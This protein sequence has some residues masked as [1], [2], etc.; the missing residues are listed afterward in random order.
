MCS[1]EII[2]TC[3][4]LSDSR[5]APSLCQCDDDK[6]PVDSTWELL[7]TQTSSSCPPPL[8]HWSLALSP[9][10]SPLLSSS[11]SSLTSLMT[12]CFTQA[13]RE[14]PLLIT[15]QTSRSLA[16]TKRNREPTPLEW[17]RRCVCLCVRAQTGVCWRQASDLSTGACWTQ[18]LSLS[19]LPSLCPFHL[20]PVF[21]TEDHCKAK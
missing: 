10:L 11:P 20:T 5:L 7:G 21:P 4:W 13:F 3:Q 2:N 17:W 19:P 16:L 8:C 1:K 15:W 18:H 12:V 14:P 9:G 6:R